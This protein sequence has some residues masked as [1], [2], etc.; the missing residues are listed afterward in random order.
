MNEGVVGTSSLADQGGPSWNF[1]LGSS[2]ANV[3]FPV[4]CCES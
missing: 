2:A 4:R 1:L 3:E